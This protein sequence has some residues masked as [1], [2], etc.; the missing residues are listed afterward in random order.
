MPILHIEHPITDYSTWRRAFDNF[1]PAR[2][3]AG[4]QACRVFQPVDDAAYIVLDLDFET[5]DK[6]SAFLNFLEG[7][8]WSTPANSP[9]LV[10]S[11]QA[12]ILEPAGRA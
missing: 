4:V 5:T 6:A 8:V 2:E 12:K 9:G 3:R 1:A 11:P 7:T 10:G